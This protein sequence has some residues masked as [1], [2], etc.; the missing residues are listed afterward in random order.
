MTD[1]RD[2][3]IVPEPE[4]LTSYRTFGSARDLIAEA[5]MKRRLSAADFVGR[6]ALAVAGYDLDLPWLAIAKPE[7]AIYDLRTK[8]RV[9]KHGHDFGP[10]QIGRIDDTR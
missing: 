9:V 1:W 2:N 4:I 6:S 8:R 10:W 5:A 3:L 7:C